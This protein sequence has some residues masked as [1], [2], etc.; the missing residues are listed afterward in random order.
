MAE[1]VR[2]VDAGESVR[3]LAEELGVANSALTRML[4]TQG[5]SVAKRT[6]SDT[7]ARQMA[8]EYEVGATMREIET[9]HGLSHEAVPRSLHR[10]GVTMRARAPRTQ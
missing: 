4:R 2:R 8:K 5:A 6:V 3:P 7:T 9:K 1:L 10:S